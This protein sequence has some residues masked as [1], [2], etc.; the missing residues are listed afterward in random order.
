MKKVILGLILTISAL[1][2]TGCGSQNAWNGIYTNGTKYSIMI[3]TK[4]SKVASIMVK[5]E[6]ENF[7]FYP[8]QYDNSLNV[9]ENTLTMIDGEKLVVTKNKDQ[10]TIKLDSEDKG[11]WADVEGVYIKSKNINGFNQNQF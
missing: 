5:Q 11:V 7:N 6:G 1:F 10:I 2:L 4:D 3:Y 8:V 9:N